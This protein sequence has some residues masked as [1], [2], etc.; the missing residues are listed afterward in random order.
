MKT[1]IHVRLLVPSEHIRYGGENKIVAEQMITKEVDQD[2]LDNLLSGFER[3]E[4][5]N[6][7]F[8]GDLIYD[9]EKNQ[10]DAKGHMEKWSKEYVQNLEKLGWEIHKENLLYHGLSL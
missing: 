2:F 9:K 10:F 3:I 7:W 1:N 8:V 4:I 5:G 6:G